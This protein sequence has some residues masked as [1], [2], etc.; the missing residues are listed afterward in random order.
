MCHKCKESRKQGVASRDDG[1]EEL[2]NKSDELKRA[3]EQAYSMIPLSMLRQAV[4]KVTK[5]DSK[6]L[7]PDVDTWVEEGYGVLHVRILQATGLSGPPNARPHIVVDCQGACA[8]TPPQR[9]TLAPQWIPAPA[10]AFVIHQSLC[11]MYVVVVDEATGVTM[12]IARVRLHSLAPNVRTKGWVPLHCAKQLHGLPNPLSSDLAFSIRARGGVLGET[13]LY[14]C[15]WSSPSPAKGSVELELFLHVSFPMREML[16]C[17]VP[18]LLRLHDTSKIWNPDEQKLILNHIVA[19]SLFVVDVVVLQ[20]AMP[21]ISEI[22]ALL[23]WKSPKLSFA[24]L[25]CILACVL[26]APCIWLLMHPVSLGAA[27]SFLV[28]RKCWLRR[29]RADHVNSSSPEQ[30]MRPVKSELPI[31]LQLLLSRFT[32]DKFVQ[33]VIDARTQHAIARLALLVASSRRLTEH[34]RWLLGKGRKAQQDDLLRVGILLSLIWSSVLLCTFTEIT[35]RLCLLA[36]LAMLL[37]YAPGTESVL[38]I[39]MGILRYVS[40]P[41]RGHPR[42]LSL[43]PDLNKQTI[44][45]EYK[46]WSVKIGLKEIP[47]VARQPQF[48]VPPKEGQYQLWQ[49]VQKISTLV[50]NMKVRWQGPMSEDVLQKL[51][52]RYAEGKA[53]LGHLLVD[54]PLLSQ[55]FWNWLKNKDES[56]EK[57]L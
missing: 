12:G 43:E 9:K 30:A 44:S 41:P 2:V 16:S 29:S 17:F 39:C 6:D 24:A 14:L 7:V 1:S 34:L 28:A 42:C 45:E 56:D 11:N 33:A 32:G 53:L 38:C 55:F 18:P 47:E 49:Y 37:A 31:Y 26:Q 50:V 22:C 19:D 27:V 57:W 46:A 52:R 21:M 4:G 35:R 48:A 36:S 3:A 5:M 40:R 25:A 10:Y 20:A 15:Q 54:L 13:L 51:W 8:R 23:L